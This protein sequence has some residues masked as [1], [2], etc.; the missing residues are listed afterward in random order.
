MGLDAVESRCPYPF[1]T[2][3]E[4]IVKDL[5]G[6][7]NHAKE[8]ANKTIDEKVKSP[9][10]N[11]A[12]GIDQRFSPVVDYFEVAVNRL[13]PN[14]SAE[15]AA[16]TPDAK[17]Q[18]QRAY[19]LSKELSDQLRT[20]SAEQ[21]NELKAHN[22]LVKRASETAHDLSQLAS[23]SYGTVQVKVQALSDTM[24][25]ELQK[26]QSTT[27]T[28]PGAIQA[29]FHDISQHLNE[30]ISDLSAVIT[31]PDPLQEKVQKLR[32]TV[33]ECVN[34]LLD[35]AR[36]RVQAILGLVKAQADEKAATVESAANGV[37][38]NGVASL[39]KGKGN[40]NGNGHT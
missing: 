14:G 8:V 30:A 4:D 9:A 35:A 38:Q 27:A 17:F 11:V 10:Y 24:L 39:S 32:D 26:I 33:Q 15:P 18:Y 7:S 28:L 12:Q 19:Y 37:V 25:A 29:S 16:S 34:P 3:P 36:A 2:T 5:K 31:S 13:H 6:H 20:Y 23:T 21:I 1:K 22:A 40:G